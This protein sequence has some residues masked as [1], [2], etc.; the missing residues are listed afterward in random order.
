M[1]DDFQWKMTFGGRHPSVK[2]D[3]Q[4]ILVWEDLKELQI[5]LDLKDTEELSKQG[6]KRFIDKKIDVRVLEY[7]NDIKSKHKKVCHIKHENLKIQKHL[8]NDLGNLYPGQGLWTE[9]N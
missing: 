7:L 2:D 5:G 8:N 4:W 3:L 1:E 9:L 6:F